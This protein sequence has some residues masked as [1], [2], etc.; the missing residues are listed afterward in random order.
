[1]QTP[2]ALEA[3]S[4]A[5]LLTLTGRAKGVCV[6]AVLAGN[7]A[8]LGTVNPGCLVCAIKTSRPAALGHST[9]LSTTSALRLNYGDAQSKRQSDC[10]DDSNK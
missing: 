5:S 6:G 4:K 7:S 3:T 8:S 2:S 9:A 1:L 10:G